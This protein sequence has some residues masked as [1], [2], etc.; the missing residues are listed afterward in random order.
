[1]QEPGTSTFQYFWTG[2]HRKMTPPTPQLVA[3]RTR[4]KRILQDQTIGLEI[5]QKILRYWMRMENLT[6]LIAKW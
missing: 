1:M 4:I 2:L 5:F 6:R 3:T